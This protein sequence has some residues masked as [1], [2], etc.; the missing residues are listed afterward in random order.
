M[1]VLKAPLAFLSILV[2]ASAAACSGVGQGTSSNRLAVV[3]TVTQVS[4]LVRSV[5]GDRI[6]QTAL[7]TPRD[8]P[9]Q[10]ELKPDQVT[11]LGRARIVFE[12][13]AG[14][15]KW[16]DQ[17]VDAAHVK[18]RV[19]VL[20]DGLKLRDAT[21]AEA[22][23]DP[24]WWYDAD[25]A[26]LAADAIATALAKQDPVGKDTYQK[27]ADAL[28]QRLDD[29]DRQ[30]HSM[31]DPIPAQR[32]LFVANHDAFNYYLARY[33]ITLVGDIVPSTDSIAAVRPADIA[34]LV[35]AIKQRHVCAIF[36]ETT[37]DPRFAQQISSESGAKVFDGKLY[38]DA[39]GDPGSPGGTLEGALVR[40]GELMASAFK[41]C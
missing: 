27:N 8:D 29:A 34:K 6:Q 36:T 14:L 30:I 37:I 17:G 2:L 32:R 20:A 16:M 38:G 7:L 1:L 4:A 13:G 5:G 39:I 23:K 35:A 25:N 12:S 33:N 41:S 11:R 28:K 24:H 9:H 31:I 10:Y 26:K 22:G 19:V 18:D 21:G 15:D 3:T 40:N